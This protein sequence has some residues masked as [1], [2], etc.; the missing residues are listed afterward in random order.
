MLRT[1]PG[2]T[3]E[4]WEK[5][6]ERDAALTP[7]ERKK[8]FDAYI[9]EVKAEQQKF[10]DEEKKK[11]QTAQECFKNCDHPNSLENSEA[12]ILWIVVM[13]VGAIFKGNWMIWIFSTVIWLRYITRHERRK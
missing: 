9:A 13:V 7:E 6:Y 4:E 11:E 12:T 3:R 2:Q 1:W 5:E 8:E 10:K